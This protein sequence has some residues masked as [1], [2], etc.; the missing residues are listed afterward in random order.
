MYEISCVLEE[1]DLVALKT[2]LKDLNVNDTVCYKYVSLLSCD[3]EQTFPQY[4]SHFCDNRHRFTID[5]LK[6]TFVVH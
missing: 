4:K 6:M 5:N 1:R 2:R 3:V